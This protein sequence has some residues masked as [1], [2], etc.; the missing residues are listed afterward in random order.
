VVASR[1]K[2]H[3]LQDSV[4]INGSS[5]ALTT[6]IV[7]NGCLA[8]QY[9][10]VSSLGI[11]NAANAG[12][13]L[14][15]L[16]YNVTPALRNMALAAGFHRVIS[17]PVGTRTKLAALTPGLH[18]M[19][20]DSPHYV[21][22]NTGHLR[23]SNN[24]DALISSGKRGPGLKPTTILGKFNQW[25]VPGTLRLN[26]GSNSR[27][28]FLG[29]VSGQ[30]QS[31]GSI[32]M[33]FKMVTIPENITQTVRMRVLCPE[34]G[35]DGQD[36]T[37][38]GYVASLRANGTINLWVSPSDYG[39]GTYLATVH[40]PVLTA[41]TEYEL[42]F[43]WNSTSIRMTRVDTGATSGWVNN[44]TYRAPNHYLWSTMTSGLSAV[45]N[46]TITD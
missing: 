11:S 2:A 25:L 37:T 43:E 13:T 16:P 34:E 12:A 32:S 18:G 40:G 36:D 42:L 35:T 45:T 30:V 22:R 23:R 26:S 24:I 21:D 6:A 31:S 5:A 7:N 38:R 27:V 14:I 33:K 41:G 29:D 15:E 9:G 1:I 28:M 44:T 46:F 10:V 19:V 3:G 17:G 8:H 20:V 39:A 4:F